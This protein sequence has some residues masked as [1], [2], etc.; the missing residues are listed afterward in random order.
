MATEIF[1]LGAFYKIYNGIL[2]PFTFQDF[3]FF[4]TLCAYGIFFLD[5][6]S[7]GDL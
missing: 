2:W 3:S 6:Y 4:V 1:K 5:L 7:V